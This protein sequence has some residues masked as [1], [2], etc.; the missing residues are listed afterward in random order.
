MKKLLVLSVLVAVWPASA[1][2]AAPP[3]PYAGQCGLPVSQ[4][5]WAEY[6]WTTPEFTNILG[7][8]G[9]VVAGSSGDYPAQMRA[10]G[11]ATEYFDL[12]FNKRIGTT[13]APADPSLMPAKAKSLFDFAVQQS[14]CATPVIVLNEL[15]GAA[16]VTPWS[17]NNAQYRQNALSFVQNLASLGAH[18][19]LLVAARPY[20]GGD[21]AVWW[22]QAA[23]SAELVRE[24]YIPATSTW[25]LGPILGNRTLRA[26]YRQA[27]AD[28]TSLGI[29][30]D[31]LGLMVSFATTKGFGGRNGLA[32]AADWYQV[33]KWQAL[34]LKQV[35]A[36]TGI[37][38]VWSWGWPE[39]SAGE[40]DP[41]KPY[42]LCAWLWVRSLSFCNAPKAIGPTFVTSRT[43][44]QL[45][46][47]TPGTQC[48]IGKQSLSND[49]IQ[50]LQLMTGDRETAY[51]AL[52]QRL[53]ESSQEPV[54]DRD[55]LAAERAVITQS[56]R[57]SRGAY[58]AA[59][60]RANATVAIARGI[61]ADQL[62]RSKVEASLPSGTPSATDVQTFYA[63]YPELPVRLVQAKPA[64]TWL[65]SKTR[66][67]A[68]GEVAPDRLFSLRTGQAAVVRTGD[69][70]FSVKPLRDALSL[71]AVPLA[72][73]RPA[74]VAA[75]RAF[76]R[77]QAFEHW[78]IFHQRAALNT[79]ICARDDLPQPAA[80][81]LTS[82]VPFLRLA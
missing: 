62:R 73:V 51:S 75:L 8:P 33:V 12:N 67:L 22:Q 74:I 66:G 30:P 28:F 71:G 65:G 78:T 9:L 63:S 77:G 18:P 16:L 41:A 81:D 72:N 3:A 15:S 49:A 21:A 44:G 48:L 11:A 60:G 58:V 47:L 2:A 23:A 1:H 59:L 7:K 45:S 53:I 34:A 35:A 29:T 6:G 14:G 50:E 64:P 39:W 10:K 69:G 4:P 31:R 19:V 42:A 25:N 17:A 24:D 5:I 68:L 43:E 26:S 79:A 20:T 61:L 38:S 40:T 80:V 32:P 13:T 46:V 36:E 55:V 52:F 54:S 76:G 27:V 56:F 82:Y 37:A 57:G 70:T